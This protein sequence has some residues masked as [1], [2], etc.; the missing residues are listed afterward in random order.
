MAASV[1]SDHVGSAPTILALELLPD[2]TRGQLQLVFRVAG[3][4]NAYRLLPVRD[5]RQPRFWGLAV[6]ERFGDIAGTLTPLWAGH[7][8]T[9]RLAIPD[10]LAGIRED[11]AAWIGQPEREGLRRILGS[12]YV[13]AALPT[14]RR[15][16]GAEA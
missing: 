1:T 12:R 15:Q 10:L 16:P 9:D 11:P 2:E 14:A 8:D 6:I 7:W 3:D 13:P 5:P 4:H